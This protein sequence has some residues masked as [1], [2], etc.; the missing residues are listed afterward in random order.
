MTN[1]INNNSQAE[2][3]FCDVALPAALP[4]VLT[5]RWPG[6]EKPPSLGMRV[7]VPLGNRRLTGVVWE[8]HSRVPVGYTA[9]DIEAVV[10]NRP[11]LTPHGVSLM[12]W[13]SEYYLCAL[14]DVVSAALPSGMKLASKTRIRLNPDISG[15]AVV[16]ELP[17][18]FLCDE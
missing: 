11:V 15:W 6:E 9:R 12:T 4:R 2:M 1:V 7:V 17:C 3:T 8:V 18:H 16:F 10:D 14:G 5:Y 13:M